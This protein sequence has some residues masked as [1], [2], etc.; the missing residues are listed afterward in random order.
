MTAEEA[1]HAF[2]SGLAPHLQK[3]V[4]AHVQGDLEAAMAM[5]QRLEVYRGAGDGAK[6]GGEK[7]GPGKFQK[8]NKK[9]AALVV[10][11]KEAE[12]IVQVIHNQ[13]KKGKG[14]GKGRPQ[15]QQ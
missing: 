13:P 3:H 12:E 14:K 7:K 8:R 10:Q 11:E 4:G 6:A 9:G 1:F 5:A 2:L 15:Q